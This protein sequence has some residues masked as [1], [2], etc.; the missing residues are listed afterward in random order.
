MRT[1]IDENDCIEKMKNEF[2]RR[3]GKAISESTIVEYAIRALNEK[4]KKEG[5][6]FFLG[7]NKE[8]NLK[9][10]GGNNA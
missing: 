8:K 4:V 3:T 1:V 5:A 7:D 9:Q 10:T 2:E 6:R